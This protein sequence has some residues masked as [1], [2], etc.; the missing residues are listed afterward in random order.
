MTLS[1]R[2][3]ICLPNVLSP[4][5]NDSKLENLRPK[6]SMEIERPN[7]DTLKDFRSNKLIPLHI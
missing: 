7:H 2:G 5:K 3:M 1:N 6:S 4:R